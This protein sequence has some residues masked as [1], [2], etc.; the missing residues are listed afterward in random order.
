MQQCLSRMNI[1]Q[2]FFSFSQNLSCFILLEAS[3][4]CSLIH[5]GLPELYIWLPSWRSPMGDLYLFLILNVLVLCV[6][7][8]TVEPPTILSY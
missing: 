1:I 8:Y 5:K 6:N 2:I 3:Y 7:H 4:S